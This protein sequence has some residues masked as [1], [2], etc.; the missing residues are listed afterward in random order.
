MSTTIKNTYAQAATFR[1][2]KFAERTKENKTALKIDVAALVHSMQLEGEEINIP[3]AKVKIGED[4][5]AIERATHVLNQLNDFLSQVSDFLARGDIT[6]TQRSIFLNEFFG[7][8]IDS[9]EADGYD[10]DASAEKLSS[11]LST[12]VSAAVSGDVA[13]LRNLFTGGQNIDER[14]IS[15]MLKN[16]TKSMGEWRENNGVSHNP[17]TF[18]ED[19]KRFKGDSEAWF[20]SLANLPLQERLTQI[21]ERRAEVIAKAE[22]S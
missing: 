7:T 19:L 14:D 11:A 9:D 3:G 12:L 10:Y 20:D 1:S 16:A 15:A 2:N 6:D 4:R 21:R 22:S 13:A 18:A 8:A 5:D 17:D